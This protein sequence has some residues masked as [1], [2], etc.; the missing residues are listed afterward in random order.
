MLHKRKLVGV[1]HLSVFRCG[2]MC[3]CVHVQTS[4]YAVCAAEQ[5]DSACHSA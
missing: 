2:C 4:P 5:Q 3:V 1:L